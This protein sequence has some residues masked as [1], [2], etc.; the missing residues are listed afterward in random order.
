[1]GRSL[2]S[3][4][5]LAAI[6]LL[7]AVPYVRA[8]IP[9]CGPNNPCP[10][11]A[12]CCSQYGQCGVGAYCLGGCDPLFSHQL[13]SCV[14]APVC[15]S[16]KFKIDGLSGVTDIAK[17]LGD[18][19]KANWVSTGKPLEYEG[20][21]LLTMAQDTVGTLLASTHYVWYGKITAKLSTS[22]GKGVVT[23]FIMMSDVKDE[24]DFEFIGTDIDHAQSNFYSQGVTNYDNGEHLDM[25]SDTANQE[26]E[27]V[28][29]WQPDSLTWSIDGKTMRTLS[30]KDTWNATSNRFDYPQTPSRV[31]LSLWP[32]GLPSNGEGTIEWAGGLVDWNS[33]YMQNGYYYAHF[34]S[35]DVECYDPPSG[36]TKSGSKT[37]TYDDKAGTNDTVV[38]SDKQVIL[39]SLSATGEDPDKGKASSSSSGSSSKTSSA[40]SSSSTAA[41]P[42]SVPG[43]SGGGNRGDSGTVQSSDGSDSSDS[44]SGSSSSDSS[45]SSGSSSSSGS[46]SFSQGND[47]SGS[48]SEA[49]AGLQGVGASMIAFVAAFASLLML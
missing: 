7:S 43:M 18:A 2:A 13:D 10:A 19:S 25:S 35:I 45:D 38:I 32:A 23:A 34:S 17:Y 24:I 21:V 11:S 42:E 12:P 14:P 5:A 44:S 15:D 28:I 16:D 27:Y 40:S 31:M 47:D 46:Q 9:T 1:M 48:S 8:D 39:G 26:H 6:T 49:P 41:A 20:G 4:A 30:R 37:Y 36:V 3:A 22:Q 33:Q 29:D